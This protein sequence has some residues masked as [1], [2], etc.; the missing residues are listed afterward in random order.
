MKMKKQLR[1]ALLCLLTL[2]LLLCLLSCKREA[3][4]TDELWASATYSSDTSF[5]E[6][7]STVYVEVKA[8]EKSVTFTI[9]TDEEMLGNALLAHDLIKGDAG[10]YGL[11]VTHVNGIAAVWEENQ[12]YWGFFSNGS[13]LLNAVDATPVEDG[14][15]YEIVYTK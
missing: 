8:G 14:K 10:E 2:S 9:K 13:L 15:H 6:G 5:G 7:A 3:P 1:A 11:Y 4:A 12:S